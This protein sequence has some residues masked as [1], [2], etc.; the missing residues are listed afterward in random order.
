[1]EEPLPEV[2]ARIRDL[3]FG[4]DRALPFNAVERDLGVS[5]GVHVLH[6][7]IDSTHGQ[8]VPGLL[9]IAEN[10][11][12]SLPLIVLQHGA[13]SRKED[14]YISLTAQRWARDGFAVAAIDAA[15]NGER[16]TRPFDPALIWS[17][18]WQRRDHAIQMCVDLH[19]ALDYLAGRPEVDVTR[20]GYVGFSMGTING[21]AFVA[22]DPRVRAAVFCIGGARLHELRVVGQDPALAREHALV[23][24]IIDPEHFAPLI[25][26]RPV[27]MINGRQDEVV[28]PA[29]A[30]AL[31]VALNEPKQIVWYDGGH[32]DLRGQHFKLMEAFLRE[33]L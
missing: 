21:V 23:A 16:R 7:A 14:P 9:W 28:P 30:E 11:P 18:P 6:F 12:P 22:R 25:A 29:A 19:R 5:E 1:M 32:T 20:A 15:G 3:F 17:L 10:A 24:R 31:Y 4:Y 8:R 13:G 2:D 26:P 27:L 33:H